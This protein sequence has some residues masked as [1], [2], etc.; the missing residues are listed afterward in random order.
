MLDVLAGIFE[1]G[2]K[3]VVG[4]KRWE[5]YLLHLI[6]GIL[7]TI[8]AFK[9]ELYGL[10]IITLPSFVINVRNAVKWYR[11]KNNGQKEN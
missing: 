5:G 7:W 10:L 9:T 1:L 4:N 2:G 3:I 8:V 11:E 6:S